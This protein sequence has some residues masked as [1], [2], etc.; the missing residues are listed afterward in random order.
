MSRGPVHSQTSLTVATPSS[1][2]ARPL[3]LALLAVLLAFVAFS[4]R[5]GAASETV[6]SRA[7]S[8]P[9][10]LD[11]RARL[12]DSA[13]IQLFENYLAA[14]F[15]ENGADIHMSFVRDVLN[16]DLETFSLGRARSIGVGR[17]SDRRGMLFVY[18]LSGQRLRIEVGPQLEGV[19][20][21][22][23]IG[24][25]MRDHARAFFAAGNPGLGL[26]LTLFMLQHRLREASLGMVYDPTVI[27]FITDSVRLAAGASAT[28]RV[29]LGG[30]ST[31]FLG[32]PAT[33]VQ[34][35]HF[36]PQPTVMAAYRRYL[37]WLR[38][39][40][41]RSDVPLFTEQSQ[42]HLR[43]LPMTS[44]YNDYI[45]VAEYGRAVMVDEREDL[46]MMIFTDTPLVS[47]H[48]FRRSPN[49]WQ[50][51]I[52]AEVRDTKNLVGGP[53]TWM[54]APVRTGDGYSERFADRWIDVMG[55][56]RLSEGDNRP[57]PIRGR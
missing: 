53:Y 12:L 21:D 56:N 25:L 47:P 50:M 31:R 29:A 8:G 19:F 23:F 7:P 38:D 33:A 39:G 48:F 54:L 15:V 45:L 44:A 42:E 34:R 9:R 40:G 41:F 43:M 6:E 57:L 36:A 5:S 4:D 49:G 17:D 16:G 10:R 11:D 51:D 13:D 46:A 18:D 35:A 24:Y 22:G 27:S 14:I 28:A 2:R 30:D 1:P 32:G 20:P 55:V 37:E 3:L 26:R 52:A